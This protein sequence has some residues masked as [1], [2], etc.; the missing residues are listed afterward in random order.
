MKSS[1]SSEFEHY[2]SL[3]EAA[4]VLPSVKRELS[5]VGKDLYRIYQNIVLYKRMLGLYQEEHEALLPTDEEKRDGLELQMGEVEAILEKR[6]AEFE[7][8]HQACREAFLEKGW[9]LRDVQ[10]GRVD[11]PYQAAD[12]QVYLLCWRRSD[13]GVLYFYRFDESFRSKKPIA[14][15][16]E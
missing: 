3:E 9:I 2:F 11:F 6:V 4:S 12:G 16:P 8:V 15:L 14:L 1:A 10:Q 7:D 5:K 13:D